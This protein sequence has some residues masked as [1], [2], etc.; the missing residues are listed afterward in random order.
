[1]RAHRMML[2]FTAGAM[3]V[4]GPARGA[5]AQQLEMLKNTTPE[6]RAKVQTELMKTKLDLTAEQEPK[7]AAL[8][9]KYAEKS[10][11]I[12]K[13]SSGPFMKM[14]RLRKINAEKDAELKQV[15]TPAQ[16][17]KLQAAKE[18]MRQKFEEKM[19]QK[20]KAGGA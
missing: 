1:M 13:G 16:Y 5:S 10:D 11:P 3:L 17:Q 14:R 4:L 9:L 12:L 2:I 20:A 6:E 19:A 8:N 7:V 15:L 18:E